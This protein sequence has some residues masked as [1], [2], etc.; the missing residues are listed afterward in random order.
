[1]WQKYLFACCWLV[2]GRK[3]AVKIEDPETECGTIWI[4]Q[5]WQWT[6]TIF[7]FICILYNIICI[8]M[9]FYVLFTYNWRAKFTPGFIRTIYNS[10]PLVT[11]T[12]SQQRSPVLELTEG[13]PWISLWKTPDSHWPNRN[14]G[15]SWWTRK[16]FRRGKPPPPMGPFGIWWIWWTWSEASAFTYLKM[17][18]KYQSKR[19]DVLVSLL[20]MF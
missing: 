15:R 3:L 1:M 16:P 14:R 8:F 9:Y 13:S 4:Y 18:N 12:A 17:V 6:W 19:L 2:V 5:K 7:M 20:Y 10:Q 11:L